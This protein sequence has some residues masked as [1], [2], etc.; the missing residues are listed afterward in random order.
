MAGLDEPASLLFKDG[1]AIDDYVFLGDVELG[2]A[3]VDLRADQLFKLGGVLGAAAAGGHEGADA[4]VDR[5]AALDDSGD[6]ADDGE[7]F[8]K[9]LFEGGPVARLRDFGRTPSV[10]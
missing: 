3:A 4:H 2:D 8:S 5:E 1:A 7:L 6:G 10:L 9:R